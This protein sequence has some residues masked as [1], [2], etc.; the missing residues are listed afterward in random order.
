MSVTYI[1]RVDNGASTNLVQMNVTDSTATAL[2]AGYV[3]AQT[4]TIN[5]LND[6][7]WTW[8]PGDMVLLVASDGDSWVTI[9][10]NF[11]SFLLVSSSANT[12]DLRFGNF[13]VSA[14]Q[15]D[16]MYATPLLV[17]AGQGANTLIIPQL[18]TME[19][20]Y[21]SAAFVGGGNVGF[22]YG[23]VAHLA[24]TLATNV[25]QAT[26]F[27]GATV[28]TIYNFNN[29]VGNGSQVLSSVGVNNGIYI[30]NDTAA[31]TVGTGA[32]FNGTI[33][34]RVFPIV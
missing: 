25:E 23:P 10:A 19:L 34:Y 3:T 14:A 7:G 11:T 17:L 2:T 16:A 8:L 30:S 24:G 29:N 6:G 26:D 5:T 33:L 15:F 12:F 28:N 13:T 21:G 4:S 31:F 18:V 20:V 32:V 1:K 22:E 9:N 27:T